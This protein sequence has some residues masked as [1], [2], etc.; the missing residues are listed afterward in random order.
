MR[1]PCHGTYALRRADQVTTICEGLRKDIAERGISM[2]KITV[3]PNA[4][5][6]VDSFQLRGD[7]DPVLRKRLGLEGKTVVGFVGSFY[8]YEGLDLLVGASAH[9][10]KDSASTCG[11]CWRAAAPRRPISRE[12]A[13]LGTPT[14]WCLRGVCPMPKC[15]TTTT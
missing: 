7:A 6:D 9:L 4:K 2:D 10:L 1:D 14:R 5:L 11:F 12:V 3:I 13:A 15:R 8:G